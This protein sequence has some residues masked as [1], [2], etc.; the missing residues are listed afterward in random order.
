MDKTVISL[1]E[2]LLAAIRDVEANWEEGDLSG[3]VD[4]LCSYTLDIE[5]IIA[6]AAPTTYPEPLAS[7]ERPLR[8]HQVSDG[9][10]RVALPSTK[11]DDG[12]IS[13]G[14]VF[15]TRYPTQESADAAIK[16][17]EQK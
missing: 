12:S 16:E 11:N 1:L 2:N 6:L 3:A 17:K 14:W 4:N 8:S 9:S 10:W 7:Y 13:P 5:G 15:T